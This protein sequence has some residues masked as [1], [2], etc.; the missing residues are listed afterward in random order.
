[1]EEL[2]RMETTTPDDA[3][4]G[5]TEG[6]GPKRPPEAKDVS[7]SVTL[8]GNK[9]SLLYFGRGVP[10][11]K[12]TASTALGGTSNLTTAFAPLERAALYLTRRRT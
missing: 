7:P 8:L 12:L 5:E 2:D 11:P 4:V 9:Q 1:M 6:M 10:V 3:L